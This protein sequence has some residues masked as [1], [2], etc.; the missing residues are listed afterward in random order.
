MLKRAIREHFT[1]LGFTK[2]ADGLLQLPGSDKDDVRR[3]HAG[4]RDERIASSKPFIERNLGRLLNHFADGADIE[5]EKISLRLIRVKSDTWQSNLFRLASLTWSVPVSSGFGRRMRYLV[6]DDGHDRLAGLIALGDPVFNLR[7]RDNLI[8]WSVGD[9]E[10]R[11]VG[12]MDAYVLGAIPP[13]SMLLGGKAVAC[14]VRSRDILND[15]GESYG[16]SVGIISGKAKSA[17]LLAVTT[18]SSMGRSSVYNR[19]KLSGESYFMPIGYTQGWGHFHI[20]EQLFSH[21]RTFLRLRDHHYADQHEYGGGP[22]WR[23]RTIKAALVELGVSESVLRHG[24]RREVF[25]AQMATNS[26]EILRNGK[27]VPNTAAL[28]T[29]EEISRKAVDRWMIPRA[30]RSTD[31]RQWRRSNLQELLA[32]RTETNDGY[33]EAARFS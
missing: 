10:D 18:S 7:V 21:M 32:P 22:N 12:I 9:R 28:S 16:S 15:F 27:G 29:V 13:Y 6:W 19:L 4:Q 25:I 24:I 11:L 26:F 30:L 17:S 23:L 1:K 31:F 20:T 33:I 2:G 8:G 3:L 14:L 5:P